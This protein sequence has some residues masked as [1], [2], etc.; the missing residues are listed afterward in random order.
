MPPVPSASR[1]SF[2][3]APPQFA[4]MPPA[5]SASRYSFSSASPKSASMPPAPSAFRY[6]F[7]SA[8]LQSASMPPAPSFPQLP[9][10]IAAVQ[11][12]IADISFSSA[13]FMNAHTSAATPMLLMPYPSWAASLTNI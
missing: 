5:P 12:P 1:Y 7:L 11:V 4:S 13:A 10:S 8:P 9:S 3:S 6:S 2:S